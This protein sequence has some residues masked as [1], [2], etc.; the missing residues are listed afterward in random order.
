MSQFVLADCARVVDLVSENKERHLGQ[1]LHREQSVQLGLGLDEPFVVLRVDQED[2]SADFGEVVPP[3]TT[4]YS[5]QYSC[6]L[7][8]FWL[9]IGDCRLVITLLVTTQVKGCESVVSNS[10]FLRR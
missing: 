8:F 5:G 10:K 4:G 1:L 3:Q 9:L 6:L 7:L 2:D